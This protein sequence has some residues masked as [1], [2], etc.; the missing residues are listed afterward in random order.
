MT[1][2]R[3]NFLKTAAAGA[4]IY[5]L[6]KQA[7]SAAHMA[8]ERARLAWVGLGGRGSF[9]MRRALTIKNI[10]VVA[11]CD[12]R[13]ERAE[14]GAEYVKELREQTIP[15]YNDFRKMIETEK[16]D[17]V[18]V[19]TEVGRHAEVVVPL[20]EAGVNCLSEK[21]MEASIEAVDAITR[22][23]RKSSSIYQVA[24]QRRSDTGFRS[25]IQA[26]RDGL[27]GDVVFMQGQWHWQN[28]RVG[29]WVANVDMSGGKLNEQACHHMDLMNWVMGN[30][31]PETCTCTAAIGIK[32]D[33][34]YHHKSENFSSASWTWANGAILSYTHLH[35]V[36]EAMTGEKSWVM[37]TKGGLDIFKGELY[38]NDEAPR[39]VSDEKP[40]W[41]DVSVDNEFREFVDCIQNKKRPTSNHETA[42]IS[43]LMTLMA[44]KAWYRRDQNSY[45]PGIITWDE[46]G[47][48]T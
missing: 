36:P 11:S 48:T 2:N 42:R 13:Q 14:K 25:G 29:G 12:L 17:G 6:S 19:A 22:A 4:S 20:L 40:S 32:Y 9:L 16:L 18:V 26:I 23:A 38:V 7:Y 8:N 47:T 41:S 44:A 33:S 10:D 3:R 39:P 37:G 21:P 28:S 24:F 45:G 43:T 27:I 46:I 31:A 30:T 1:E 15:T 5:G 35:G 34:P